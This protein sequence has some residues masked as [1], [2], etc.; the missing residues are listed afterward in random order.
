M[1]LEA[2]IK[3]A[4][5]TPTSRGWG[6]PVI[7]EGRM[8]IGKSSRIREVAALYGMRC[9]TVSPALSGEAAFGA[10]PVPS[11]DGYLD[12]PAPYWLRGLS[13]GSL[14]LIDEVASAPEHLLPPLLSVLVEGV[15]GGGH[16]LDPGTRVVGATNSERMSVNGGRLAPN[17]TCRFGWL[18]AD[19][20]SNGERAAFAQKL[21]SYL[22]TTASG[23][24][25]IA[26]P[27]QEEEARVLAA[28]PTAFAKAAGVFAAFI[29]SRPALVEAYQEGARV[30]PNP[31]SWE[32][33]VRALASAGIHKLD[34]LDELAFV[35]AFVGEGAGGELV[36]YAESAGIQDPHAILFGGEAFDWGNRPDACYGTAA[37]CVS[38]LASLGDEN[39]GVS[40]VE[41]GKAADSYL[42]TLSKA[43]AKYVDLAVQ[44]CTALSG[45]NYPIS[46]P[47]QA[48]VHTLGRGLTRAVASA[49][50]SLPAVKKGGVKN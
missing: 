46:A 21:S 2:L 39:C 27:Y 45:V 47:L 32:Y 25:T 10:V 40:G 3:A 28:W 5:F 31:R 33:A 34:A 4:I 37:A 50:P 6:L 7:A 36:K 43:P 35:G 38:L 8:G 19:L 30:W 22:T 12:A 16:V 11:S 9:V 48:L 42:A 24:K 13:G 41:R 1:N 49:T 29:R 14:V 18:S 17:I 44:S 15:V 20:H 26:K 23:M